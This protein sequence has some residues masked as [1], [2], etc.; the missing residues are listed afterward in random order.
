MRYATSFS[1]I[2]IN[3]TGRL[4]AALFG[5]GNI[6]QEIGE[7]DG[8]TDNISP[9]IEKIKS[10]R[11]AGGLTIGQVTNETEAQLSF[12]A[13][14]LTEFNLRLAYQA[15]AP[16]TSSQ[17]AGSFSALAVAIAAGIFVNV[18]FDNCFV[19]KL[20]LGTV[21]G[22]P[23]TIGETVTQATSGATGVVGWVGTGFIEVIGGSGTFVSGQA[24]TGGTSTASA[25]VSSVVKTK[26]M[27]VC[28]AATPTTRYTYGVDYTCDADYG[29]IAGVSGGAISGGSAYVWGSYGAAA[30]STLYPM[31]APSQEL[32]LTFVSDASDNGP[33]QRITYFRTVPLLS[34]D[35]SQIGSGEATIPVQCTVMADTARPV[36]KQFMSIELFG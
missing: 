1:N 4:Y 10:N 26:D 36:G 28:D 29:L 17:A 3:G 9:S 8:L 2:R 15:A 24:I 18:G 27:I 12:G 35:R 30:K 22:G 13:R 21:T 5:A 34:G 32:T 31:S 33:R 7:L 16:D 20:S 19:T 23:F 6:G 25:P 14:E 11:V